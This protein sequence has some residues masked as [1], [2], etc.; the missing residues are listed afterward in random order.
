MRGKQRSRHPPGPAAGGGPVPRP[1][2]AALRP[3][4]GT[5]HGLGTAWLG[6]GVAPG[7]RVGSFSAALFPELV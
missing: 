7:T 1:G 2:R 6:L 3:S 5:T 4:L